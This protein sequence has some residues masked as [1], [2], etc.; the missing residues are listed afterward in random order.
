MPSI[1]K[2]NSA[3]AP[4]RAPRPE[5]QPIG[6]MP[7]PG[8]YQNSDGDFFAPEGP[9]ELAPES[10][11][12]G[13][14]NAV[15]RAVADGGDEAII[16]LTSEQLAVALPREKVEMLKVLM[17]SFDG[18]LEAALATLLGGGGATL[19]FEPFPVLDSRQE[20]IVRILRSCE[21]AEEVDQIFFQV[22][23]DRLTRAVAGEE[24]AQTRAVLQGVR[25]SRGE[26]NIEGYLDTVT[27]SERVEGNSVEFLI[28]QE[29]LTRFQEDLRRAKRFVNISVYRIQAD[30]MG[31][32]MA[33]LLIAK[34]REGVKVRVL[35]DEQGTGH[36][37][38]PIHGHPEEPAQKL[39]EGLRAG[40]IEVVLKHAPLDRGHLNHRKVFVMDDGAGGML[41]YSGGSNL[42]HEDLLQWHDQQTRIV[43]PAVKKLARAFRDQWVAE[44]EAQNARSRD[45]RE[46]QQRDVGTGAPNDL[47]DDIDLRSP[48]YDADLPDHDPTVFAKVEVV[49]GGTNVRVISHQGNGKDRNIKAM[50][51]C[52]IANAQNSIRIANPYFC[53]PEVIEALCQAS[54]EGVQVQVVLPLQNDVHIAQKAARSYYPEL[55][56]AGAEV[57]EYRGGES[58]PQMAH[59]KVALF[60]DRF[61]TCG[62]SNLDA[63][64][65]EFNDELNLLIDDARLATS[66][67][68]R[69]FEADIARSER[70]TRYSTGVEEWLAR[71]IVPLL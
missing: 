3:A 6:G 4:V 51:L 32:E 67:K 14:R 26:W 37:D 62:S 7:P 30:P 21:S 55:L 8:P 45:A 43:G 15:V 63:R 27:G 61:L 53:D 1:Q 65:L 10:S 58:Q 50:Y 47:P 17:S 44:V 28:D 2:S 49:D 34:A 9:I 46:A 52:L 33:R 36:V 38:W 42:G 11:F 54:R 19:S 39:V 31:Q 29:F 25:F 23:G 40:G 24:D 70:I 18:G 57:Y 56:A 12:G 64:S 16:A 13:M 60:D 66:V 35:L 48:F 20:A 68:E 22:N 59:Q 41:G 71:Q 5:D 69:L